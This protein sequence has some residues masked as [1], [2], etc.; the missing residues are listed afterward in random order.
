MT[1]VLRVEAVPLDQLGAGDVAALAFARQEAFALALQVA[2][3]PVAGLAGDD[4]GC[5]RP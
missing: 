3:E 1:A 2:G 5:Q 4:R